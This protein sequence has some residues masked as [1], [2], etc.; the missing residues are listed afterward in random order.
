MR[1]TG[2]DVAVFAADGR[3]LVT[4]DADPNEPYSAVRAA[5]RTGKAADVVTGEGAEAEA[6]VGGAHRNGSVRYI[7]AARRPLDD[8][9][10]ATGVVRRAFVVAAIAG[11]LVAVAAGDPDRQPDGQA[12]QAPARHRRARRTRR[13]DRRVPT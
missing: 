7:V 4:T 12:D 1:R 5:V 11:L 10:A 3:E 6:H 9:Q 2:A 8:V 13:A